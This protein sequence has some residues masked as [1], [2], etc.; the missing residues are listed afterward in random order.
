MAGL[1]RLERR[2]L[3]DGRYRSQRC[4]AAANAQPAIVSLR[5]G[6]VPGIRQPPRIC[7]IE[8]RTE[9]RHR[10]SSPLVYGWKRA[11]EQRR[12]RR[13]FGHTA[14]IHND[15]ALRHLGDDAQ[16]MGDQHDRGVDPLLQFAHQIEDL[17]L[18]RHVERGR[19]LVGDQQ[20]GLQASAIAII[21]RWR[22]PPES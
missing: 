20:L 13:R 21:T 6:T 8:R 15:D 2:R 4:S 3:G 16:I 14:G 17:R 12:N 1:L 9:P 18:D 22:M 7:P 11:A 19:R 5:E 10:L